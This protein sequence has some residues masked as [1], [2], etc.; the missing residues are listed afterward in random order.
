MCGTGGED[1]MLLYRPDEIRLQIFNQQGDLVA[2]RH[3]AVNLGSKPGGPPEYH[4]DHITYF[5]I[6][7]KRN[8]EK[9][10]SM[11]PTALDWIR[12]RI[13]LLD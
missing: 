13:P 2:L 7:S 5:D 9:T 10:I 4:P 11:P 1:S 12:A 6:S 8:F 3:F